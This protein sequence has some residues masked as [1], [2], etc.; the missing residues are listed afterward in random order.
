MFK[1][2]SFSKLGRLKF[3][4]VIILV[5]INVF[6]AIVW[7][8]FSCFCEISLARLNLGEVVKNPFNP[9]KINL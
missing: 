4:L 2:L 5:I 1:L 6:V 3:N 8:L 7:Y 9:V